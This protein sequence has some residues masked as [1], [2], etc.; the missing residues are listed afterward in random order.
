MWEWF[1]ERSTPDGRLRWG[2]TAARPRGSAALPEAPYDGLNLATHVG[3]DPRRVAAHRRTVA[4]ALGLPEP[5]LLVARQVHGA[6]VAYVDGPWAAEPAEA[7]ALVTDRPGLA[8]AVLVADCVPVLLAAPGQGV[9]AA[10]HAGRPGLVAGVVPAAVSAMREL[11]AQEI[12]AAVGP[13]VCGRCYEVPAPMRADVAAV[14]EVSATVSWTG[15]PAVDV[16]AGVVA[17]LA[18]AGV[19]LTWRPGC[20]RESAHLYSYRRDGQTGRFAGIIVR[21]ERGQS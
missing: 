14:S 9:V 15:T 6:H 4:D 13:S 2:F 10:V 20:T 17:Q 3:D 16:A 21:D 7:D 5:R 12:V 1:E 19:G 8:L 11:G 18:E